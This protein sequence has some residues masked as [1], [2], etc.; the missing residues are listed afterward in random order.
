M[1][2]LGDGV[3]LECCAV[4]APGQDESDVVR[5]IAPGEM[6][7][8]MLGLEVADLQRAVGLGMEAG[9]AAGQCQFLLGQRQKGQSL[10]VVEVGQAV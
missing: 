10:S 2:V 8:G 3:R 7:E 5:R 6:E 1:F 9:T 4:E